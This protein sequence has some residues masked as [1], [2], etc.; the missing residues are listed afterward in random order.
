MHFAASINANEH[1]LDRIT[2][3]RKRRSLWRAGDSSGLF[4]HV[5]L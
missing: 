4:G 1:L 2:M 3:G 5:S